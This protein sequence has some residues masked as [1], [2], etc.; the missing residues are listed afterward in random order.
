MPERIPNSVAKRVVFRAILASDHVTPATGKTIAVTI[1]KNGGAFANPAAGATNATAISSGFYYFDLGTGDTGTNG[2]LAWRGA[3]GTIDDA[4]DVFEVVNATN[5]GFSALPNAAAEAAGGL[6]TRGTGAGQINQ[7]ANGQIDSNTAAMAAG[8]V[9]AAAIA[10]GA[11]DADALAA[12]AVTEIRDGLEAKTVLTGTVTSGTTT[13]IVLANTSAI[14]PA[15]SVADQIKGRVVIF[16]N[17]TTTAALRG[18]AA[19]ITT[20]DVAATPTLTFAT[21]A[22]TTAPQSGD[23][24]R[25]V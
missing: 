2:P 17:D 6:Y 11:I 15:I 23:T 25:V 5:G 20:H 8:V 14:S 13:T 10:T 19:A 7:A 18:Q 1:S 24:F 21:A 3:E 9:T 22:W 16:N 4:G 12:D